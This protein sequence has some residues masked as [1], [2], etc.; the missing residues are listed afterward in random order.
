MGSQAFSAV[1]NVNLTLLAQTFTWRGRCDP[2]AMGFRTKNTR[3][4][5]EFCFF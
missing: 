1:F 2:K 4:P 3:K 5:V